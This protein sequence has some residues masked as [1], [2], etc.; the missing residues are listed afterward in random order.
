MDGSLTSDL[1]SAQALECYTTGPAY[2]AGLED[3]TGKL[4]AGYVAD[5]IVLKQ[6]PARC[7]LTGHAQ[8][9]AGSHDG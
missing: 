4:A 5:L 7:S 6:A 8:G 9:A 1:I 2:A 3:C